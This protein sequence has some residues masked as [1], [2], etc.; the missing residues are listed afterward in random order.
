M[1]MSQKISTLRKDK[2]LTLAELG[3]KVGVG[4]STVRKWETGYIENVRSDKIDK[5]ATALDTTPAYLMG[6]D[7]GTAEEKATIEKIDG[8]SKL[9]SVARLEEVE[10]TEEQDEELRDLID[11][12]L[13]KRNKK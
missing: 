7:K 1:N 2:G 4:A 9:R 3:E 11:F 5:L 8:K 6:W 12:W 10:I 13:S